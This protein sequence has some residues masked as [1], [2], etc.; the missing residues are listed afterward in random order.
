MAAGECSV[1]LS[2]AEI[3]VLAGMKVHTAVRGGLSQHFSLE[4]TLNKRQADTIGKKT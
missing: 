2:G 4:L 3:G 1:N